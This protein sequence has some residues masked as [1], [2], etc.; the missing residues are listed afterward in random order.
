[1]SRVPLAR[2]LIVDDEADL[3]TALCGILEARGY[4]T[5]GA[6]SGLQAL[7]ALRAAAVDDTTRFDVLITDL[8]MPYMHGIALLH[9]AHGIDCDL[10]SIVMTGH[11][12]VR[13]AVE[14][15]KSGATDYILKPFNLAAVAPI[16][17]RA[18]TIRGLRRQNANLLQQ[19]KDRTAELEESIRLLQVAN[20]DI[21]AYKLKAAK[22]LSRA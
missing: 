18:L 15:M 14:A 22:R 8:M 12:T 10:V 6:T 16:L 2:I 17:E 19:V 13:T 21:D 5:A 9:A 20:N 3:V 4:S 11:G 1:M 7:T